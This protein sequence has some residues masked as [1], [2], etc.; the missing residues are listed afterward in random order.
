MSD[1]D[2]VMDKM[3]QAG[4]RGCMGAFVV[5]VGLVVGRVL[6]WFATVLW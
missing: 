6:W 1:P 3:A 5:A 4:Q 2:P